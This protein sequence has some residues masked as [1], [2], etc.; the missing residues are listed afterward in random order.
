MVRE[1]V[2]KRLGKEE[3]E[4]TQDKGKVARLFTKS[5]RVQ[6]FSGRERNVSKEQKP[7]FF[8]RTFLGK[9]HLPVRQPPI[10]ILFFHNTPHCWV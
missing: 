6:T 4:R 9:V 8:S 5:E 7:V 10:P 3:T 2:I 1:R